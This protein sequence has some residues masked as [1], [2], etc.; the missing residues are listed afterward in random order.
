MQPEAHLPGRLVQ[1]GLVTELATDRE[2]RFRISEDGQ[3]VHA[4]FRPCTA[5]V[6]A[7]A[8]FG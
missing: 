4:T 2:P 1:L 5:P 6:T 3:R 7:Y 8:A